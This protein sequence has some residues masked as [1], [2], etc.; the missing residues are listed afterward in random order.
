MTTS[1]PE[2]GPKSEVTEGAQPNTTSHGKSLSVV[3]SVSSGGATG[4]LRE[5]QFCLWWATRVA[6]PQELLVHIPPPCSGAGK[7]HGCWEVGYIS[8]FIQ[9]S[10]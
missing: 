6:V 7:R 10:F 1:S 8:L 4:V 9:N 3:A 5:M 2:P